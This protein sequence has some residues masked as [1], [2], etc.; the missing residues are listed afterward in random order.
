MGGVLVPSLAANRGREEIRQEGKREQ[1][2]IPRSTR[3][4]GGGVAICWWGRGGHVLGH[5]RPIGAHGVL[6]WVRNSS[7]A[8]NEAERDTQ[9]RNPQSSPR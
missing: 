9:K 4:L 7:R 1:I 3:K 6:Q 5:Q 8:T 2:I